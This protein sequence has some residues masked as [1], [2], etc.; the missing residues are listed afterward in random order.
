MHKESQWSGLQFWSS[1][2]R[3]PSGRN[4][5]VIFTIL[6]PVRILVVYGTQELVIERDHISKLKELVSHSM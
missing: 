2:V 3:I 6:I 1:Q 5:I 4:Y